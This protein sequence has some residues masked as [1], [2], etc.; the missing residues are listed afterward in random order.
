M[1]TKVLTNKS[2]QSAAVQTPWTSNLRHLL[3]VARSLLRG[4]GI[5]PAQRREVRKV[6]PLNQRIK[7]WNVVPG[8]QIRILGDKTNRLYQVSEVNK[9]QNKVSVRNTVRDTHILNDYFWSDCI[10]RRASRMRQH[11]KRKTKSSITPDVNCSLA[12]TSSLPQ[13][14][15]RIP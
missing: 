6:V 7:W 3:P 5:Q 15:P 12:T 14:R 1:P 2:L 8:D 13:T 10:H 11:S 4:R 9:L